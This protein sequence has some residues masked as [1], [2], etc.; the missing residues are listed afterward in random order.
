MKKD[1][2]DWRKVGRDV[3]EAADIAKAVATAI[4]AAIG[5]IIAINKLKK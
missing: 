4:T 5:V 1:D 3:K 2:G